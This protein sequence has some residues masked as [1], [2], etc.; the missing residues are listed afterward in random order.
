VDGKESGQTATNTLRIMRALALTLAALTALSGCGGSSA[1]K[2]RALP[3]ISGSPSASAAPTQAASDV[4]A[5]AKAA[6]SAGAEAFAR[7]F[8]A[9][10]RHA[11]ETKNPELV[12]ALSAPGCAACDRYVNSLTRLRDN[13][14]RMGEYGVRVLSAIAPAVSGA[15]ARVDVSWA[16][17]EVVRY[18]AQGK[19]IHREGP[20]VRVDDQMS[21]LRRGDGWLVVELKSLR[22]Q[23]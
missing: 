16:S 8:Y 21:L 5:E 18:D 1:E 12:R 20:F 2:P 4:P 15:T 22:V 3:A 11:F 19:V 13:N 14:E 10:I 23:K 17:P 7:F 6:T 9:E